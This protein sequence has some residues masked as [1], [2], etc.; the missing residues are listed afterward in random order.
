[1]RGGESIEILLQDLRFGVRMLLKQ[2][3]FTLIT[4]LTL[5]LGISINTTVFTY[6]NAVMFRLLTFDEPERVA[7]IWAT[8][9]V[10]G[11][12]QELVSSADFTEWRGQAESFETMAG[13]SQYA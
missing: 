10:S 13:V 3:G 8:N 9:P 1:M 11:N 6:V 12:N 5:A 7:F 2:P 4:V